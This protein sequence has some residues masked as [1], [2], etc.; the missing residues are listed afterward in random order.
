M[1]PDKLTPNDPRVTHHTFT[2]DDTKSYHYILANP[3]GTPRATVLLIHGFPD[4]GFG[5]RYQVPHLL[6]L[7]LRVIVPDALGYGRSSAPQDLASYSLKSMSAD[8]I[9]LSDHVLGSEK[10]PIIL[11]GHDWGGALVWRL[12]LWYPERIRAV[13]SVCTP[14]G[15]PSKTYLSP[16]QV[17][18]RL[19][20]FTYQLQLI[21]PEVEEKIKGETVTRQFFNGIFG[22][23]AA[24]GG[25]ILEVSKGVV[26]ERLDSIGNATLLTPE[27]VEFYAQEYQRNGMRGPL[28]WY[29]TRKV[30]YDEELELIEKGR[31][32]IAAPSLFVLATKDSALP[33]AMSAGMEAYFDKLERKE[34]VASHWALVE[35]AEEVNGH[36]GWW[37]EGVLGGT[38]FKASI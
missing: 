11:G 35:A 26:F 8:M 21:G 13:F 36:V 27:E 30:N 29:R 2:I 24:D 32:K 5:W 12:A 10:E 28:N 22:G 15:P 25:G 37:L 33:P 6:S 14:Y 4:L 16:E 19:P 9:A 31:G 3:S 7:G 20:N 38:G 1:A 18:Q 17:V 34:V 23:R